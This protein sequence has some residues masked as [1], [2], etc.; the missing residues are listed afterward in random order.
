MV[1]IDIDYTGQLHTRCVHEPSS[2]ALETDAPRDNEGLGESF[3]PTDL[4]AT[5]V[6]TCMLTT[7]AI[8]ARRKGWAIEG[9]TAVVGK[10]MASQPHRRVERLEVEIA[11]PAGVPDE[12]RPVLERAAHTCPVKKSLHPDVDVRTGFRWS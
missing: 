11:M 4:L 3:S 9:A 8:L 5:A 6:G 10:H 1:R 2:S 12:A 7:M